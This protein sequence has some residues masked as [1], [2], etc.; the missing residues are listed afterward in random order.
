MRELEKPRITKGS[1]RRA[2]RA[3]DP[4]KVFTTFPPQFE[5]FSYNHVLVFYDSS[6]TTE[7]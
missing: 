5:F 4:L 7:A 6:L 3:L 2:L 1:F